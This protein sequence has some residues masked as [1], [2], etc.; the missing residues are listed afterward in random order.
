MKR[1]IP[2]EFQDY[3][4]V[5]ERSAMLDGEGQS[6]LTLRGFWTGAF[7][8]FFLAIGVPYANTVMHS[9][10]MAWDF[11][12]PGA[13]FLFLTLI[14]LLNVL[15]KVAARGSGRASALAA[16]AATLYLYYYWPLTDLD[17]HSPGW[18]FSTFLVISALINA[19]L[20]WRGGSLALNRSELVLVYLMLL[21]VS[22]LCTMGMSEQLLPIITAFFYYASPQNKWAEKLLPHFPEHPIL[23]DDGS[24]NRAFYE[25]LGTNPDIPYD[26]WIEPLIYWSIFLLALYVAMI[27]IAVI[28]R[29]QWMERERLAYPLTQVGVAIVAG[30]DEKKLVNGFLR[31]RAMWY[32]CA[33]PLFFGSL[34]ALHYYDPAMPMV[35][36]QWSARFLEHQSLQLRINFAMIGFSYL[37]NTSISAGLWV[38]E[39]LAK[40]ESEFFILAGVKSDQKFVYGIADQPYLA[41]QGGGALIAMVLLGLWTGREHLK[42]VFGKAFGFAPE[43]ED[44][45]EIMSYR[46]AVIG[47]IG[48]VV[49]MTGWLWLMGTKF[50]VALL[51]VGVA[52]LIFIGITRV[53]AEAGLAAVRSPMIAPDLMIQGLGSQLV[54]ASGVFNLSL[55]YIWCA[56]IRVFVMAMAANGLKLIEGMDRRSRR[57]ILWGMYLAIFIGAV[58]SCWMVL[59]MTYR[60]GGINLVGWFFKG[61]PQVVYNTA[62]RNL[63]PA[64]VAWDGLA[65]FCG[66]G[67]AML[68]MTWARQRLLWWPLHPLG[69]TVAANH[70]MDKIWF[71]VLI[72]WAIKKVVLR[73][74]GAAVYGKSQSF[75][76]GLI[77]G[78]VLCNGLWIVIDYFTGKTGN[79]IFI[80]G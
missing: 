54:G 8:S 22:A 72:A 6:G 56:D 32:G 35:N 60:H 69:F 66:G 28:L 73:F 26:A 77:A 37:I 20:V 76:L 14:G 78:E 65:F 75:F 33:I 68:L 3:L 18:I 4:V 58:G 31:N 11:N 48:G 70:L 50:W 46:S 23:V 74:G 40:V 7:L 52:L 43:V 34:K 61:G 71:S 62:M 44:G 10:F 79:M 9:T 49:V 41:Y 21:V 15:F 29:R 39:L 24:Q 63:E 1:E 16:L 30:E 13:I 27:S 36:L 57:L 59:H 47:L 45:D 17:L 53:V 67:V 42:N 25:G 55:A 5:R 12:T 51:F 38:F 80:L 19:P 64:G 2:V